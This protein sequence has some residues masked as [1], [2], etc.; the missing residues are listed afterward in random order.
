MEN[1]ALVLEGG[2]MR[3]VFTAGVLDAF[4]EA[5]I[6]FPYSIG[7][8]A[9]ACNGCSFL[10]K[11]K[12][13]AY[14]SNVT[15]PKKYGHRYLG[16]RQFLK[17]GCIFNVDLLYRA[18]P[19]ELWPY[20]FRTYFSTSE[21]FE[22]VTTNML[23]GRAEYLSNHIQEYHTLSDKDANQ[24]SLDIVLASSSLPY[25][26]DIVNVLGT[27][28]LD[29]GIV[30]SIPVVH[31][32]EQGYKRC[33]VI[34]TRNKGYRKIVRHHFLTSVL[35]SIIRWL[36]YSKYPRFRKALC[37]RSEVYNRQLELV[38]QLEEKGKIVV[39]RPK[40]PVAVDRIERN[41][42]KLQG[43]YEEGLQIGRQFCKSL[44]SHEMLKIKQI[45]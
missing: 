36:F 18:L 32:M 19:Y 1:T 14:F 4:M 5:G 21:T 37:C 24:L 20:D 15:I 34:L 2:G 7:V 33:V 3:G 12:G 39:I 40:K 42:N 43:L 26:G 22:M 29:G 28:M 8:S 25:V 38:E 10:T 44:S 9:G 23:T 6:R 35:S 45:P 13:R 31:S 41:V 11:Q 16:I 17:T 30:D 27:P